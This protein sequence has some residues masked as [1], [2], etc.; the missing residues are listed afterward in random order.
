VRIRN[1]RGRTLA[2]VALVSPPALGEALD[3]RGIGGVGRCWALLLDVGVAGRDSEH[4]ALS[5]ERARARQTR[6]R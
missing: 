2:H 3:W 4:E 6:C 1:A 5:G